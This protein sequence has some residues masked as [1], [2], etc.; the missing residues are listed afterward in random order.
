M[1]T[2]RMLL[3]VFFVS[4]SVYTVIVGINHGWNLFPVF[5]GDIAAMT[6]PGQFNVD[7]LCFLVLSGV[8][9]AWRHHFSMAGIAL[10]AI[11][12]VGGM[13]YLSLYL[14]FVSV[15]CNGDV[16]SLLL[17]SERVARTR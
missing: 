7:F 4:I 9:I 17:G 3:V 13:L 14:L 1:N 8:W 10:G 11:A 2:F 15:R 5:F 6:W 16:H 12:F